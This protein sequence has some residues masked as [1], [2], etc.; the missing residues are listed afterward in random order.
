MGANEA[1]GTQDDIED[2]IRRELGN[3]PGVL[4]NLTQP[5]EMT[6]DHLLEGVSA[7]LVVKVFGED[8]DELLLSAERV[9]AAVRTV[10]GATDVQ[11]DQVVGAVPKNQL[12]GL[13]NK[14]L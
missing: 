2:L 5:I 4:V 13:L 14:V 7:E 3:V 6:I 8:L 9:A 10:A 1:G 11:V 12:E